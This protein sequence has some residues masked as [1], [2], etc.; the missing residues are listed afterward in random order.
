MSSNFPQKSKFTIFSFF[1]PIENALGYC[2]FYAQELLPKYIL[3]P[4]LE[5]FA[6]ATQPGTFFF[7]GRTKLQKKKVLLGTMVTIYPVKKMRK[8]VLIWA[9][10]ENLKFHVFFEEFAQ[11]KKS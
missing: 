4:R 3:Q 5:R 8:H 6:L 9:F 2:E 11:K 10:F 1:F 7:P